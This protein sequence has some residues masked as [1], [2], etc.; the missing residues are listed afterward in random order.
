[1]GSKTNQV[2]LVLLRF[3]STKTSY[4]QL[5]INPLVSCDKG[6]PSH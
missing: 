4:N 5:E 1:V 6:G 3:D 2:Q